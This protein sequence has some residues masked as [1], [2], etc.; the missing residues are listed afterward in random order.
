MSNSTVKGYALG[1]DFRQTFIIITIIG[2]AAGVWFDLSM[3]YA[4]LFSQQDDP[5]VII[6]IAILFTAMM[7]VLSVSGYKTYRV[8]SMKYVGTSSSLSFFGTSHIHTLDMSKPLFVTKAKIRFY[9]GKSSQLRDSYLFSSAPITDDFSG[10]EGLKVI[11]RLMEAGIWMISCEEH[12]L[13]WIWETI[14]L[15]SIPDYPQVQ[16][17]DPVYFDTV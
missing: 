11:K 4:G 6:T 7:A 9:V 8:L 2:G 16:K 15:K 5:S 13:G 12:I 17:T 14:G 10:D 3:W 1:Q